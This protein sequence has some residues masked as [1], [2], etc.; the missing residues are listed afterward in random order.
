MSVTVSMC[1]CVCRVMSVQRARSVLFC[2]LHDAHTNAAARTSLH[3]SPWF[4]GQ[5][6]CQ[7]VCVMA[8]VLQRPP[9]SMCMCV[10]VCLHAYM[11]L[12]CA[13]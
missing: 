4:E 10:C 9:V 12:C 11:V 3:G 8:M 6:F 5:R 7:A 2:V 1:M 13:L